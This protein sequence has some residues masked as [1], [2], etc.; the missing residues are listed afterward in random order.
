MPLPSTFASASARSEGEFLGSYGYPP[1]GGPYYYMESPGTKTSAQTNVARSVVAVDSSGN[2]YSALS[3]VGALYI[4]KFDSTGSRVWQQSITVGAGAVRDSFIA[5]DSSNNVI[6]VFNSDVLNGNYGVFTYKYNNSGTLQWNS[7]I[8]ASNNTVNPVSKVLIGQ[9]DTIYIGSGGSISGYSSHI[10]TIYRLNSNGTLN[11]SISWTNYSGGSVEEYVQDFVIDSTGKTYVITSGGWFNVISTWVIPSGLTAGQRLPGISSYEANGGCTITCI[12]IDSTNSVWIGGYGTNAANSYVETFG[13]KWDGQ[14][15][16]NYVPTLSGSFSWGGANFIP[17]TS[18]PYWRMACDSN[19]NVY[20]SGGWVA[21]SN[22]GNSALF[23]GA[24]SSN[25]T[26]LTNYPIVATPRTT[27]N[28][29]TDRPTVVNNIAIDR[30]G[31]TYLGGVFSDF[32]SQ[33]VD[34]NGNPSGPV[35]DYYSPS[36]WKFPPMSTASANVSSGTNYGDGIGNGFGF[37]WYYG[38]WPTSGNS[39]IGN[40]QTS[41]VDNSSSAGLF[42][43]AAFS[44]SNSTPSTL[45]TTASSTYTFTRIT[46]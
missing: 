42:Y 18:N 30:S 41:L 24:N 5:L 33:S 28:P 46:T 25:G 14:T 9:N 10:P 43:S 8:T 4:T 32:S 1:I 7:N 2:V 37:T 36:F 31:N 15:V 13:I 3:I 35:T 19:N 44:Y 6:V 12:A 23:V 11:S 22:G 40:L 17:S 26:I 29:N 27:P 21:S 38:G 20:Q 34:K 45:N 39:P 16:Y